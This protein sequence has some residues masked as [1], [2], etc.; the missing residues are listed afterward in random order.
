[1][2]HGFS[3]NFFERITRFLDEREKGYNWISSYGS[4][5]GGYAA[6]AFSRRLRMRSVFAISP[7]FDI[8]QEWDTRWSAAARAIDRMRIVS[9]SDLS[10]GCQYYLAF[11]PYDLDNKHIAQFLRVIPHETA[12]LIVVQHSGHPSGYFLSDCKVLSAIAQAALL[13]KAVPNWR[14]QARHVRAEIPR[15]NFSL[16]SH[17]AQRGKWGWAQA[18]LSRAVKAEPLNPEYQIRLAAVLE[19]RGPLEEAIKTAA[20]AVGI[21]PTHPDMAAVLSRLLAKKGLV[22]EAH[23]H[24]D[25]AIE[26]SRGAERFVKQK[27]TLDLSVVPNQLRVRPAL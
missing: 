11:D 22:S 26:M 13:G 10:P 5:M 7:Q 27:A 16:G 25:R 9:K 20:I 23:V 15:Y 2:V 21:N 12:K 3:G 19:K 24:I 4:S 6:I 18:V 14:N 8:T 1:V 17:L